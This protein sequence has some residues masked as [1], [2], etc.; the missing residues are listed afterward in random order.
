[1]VS[2][3]GPGPDFRSKFLIIFEKEK[4]NENFEE[5]FNFQIFRPDQNKN[6]AR[7]KKIIRTKNLDHVPDH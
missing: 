7:T 4:R 3:S 5:K 1:M 6:L 2:W